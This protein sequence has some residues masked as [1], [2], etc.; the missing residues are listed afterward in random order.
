MNTPS[1]Q[2]TDPSVT[3]REEERRFLHRSLVDLDHELAAGDLERGAYDALAGQYTARLAALLRP[4]D[5]AVK[6]TGAQGRPHRLQRLGWCGAIVAVA[7]VAGL[8]VARFSGSRTAG[9]SITGSIRQAASE[10]LANCLDLASSG[11]LLDAVHCY[12]GVLK[13]EPSNVEARTY[14]GW[15]LVRAGD[16]RL[17]GAGEQDLAQAVSLDPSYPDARAFH[18]VVL[19]QLGRSK[20]AQ[21]ELAAFDALNPPKLMRDLITQFKLRER[22]AESLAQSP[23]G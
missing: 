18:A 16:D 20:E 14:R 21:A 22:I 17:R 6:E 15:S 7:I 11:A 13:D 23:T 1:S 8:A 12:D 9:K 2:R 4:G 5:T 3:T 19:N 10:Q